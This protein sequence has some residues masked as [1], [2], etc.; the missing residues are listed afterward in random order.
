MSLVKHYMIKFITL[1]KVSNIETIGKVH[2]DTVWLSKWPPQIPTGDVT[3]TSSSVSLFPLR[4]VGSWQCLSLFTA[5]NNSTSVPSRGYAE[6][7]RIPWR[8]FTT[9][10]AGN[11]VHENWKKCMKP[12]CIPQNIV[13]RILKIWRT[14]IVFYLWHQSLI[15]CNNPATITKCKKHNTPH[16]LFSPVLPRLRYGYHL[17][18]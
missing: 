7:L 8:V 9:K 4:A 6:F 1:F 3:I 10:N 12:V 17:I 15:A 11:T 2:I 16:T 14:V 18:L 5:R 13:F